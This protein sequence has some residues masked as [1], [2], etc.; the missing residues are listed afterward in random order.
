MLSRNSFVTWKFLCWYILYFD[1]S[2]VK[3]YINT[4]TELTFF[5]SP[6]IIVKSPYIYSPPPTLPSLWVAGRGFQ[7]TYIREQRGGFEQLQTTAKQGGPILFIPLYD[8]N[9]K[10]ILIS[11][12]TFRRHF[13]ASR[14][15]KKM[16]TPRS[17][18][19]NKCCQKT[20]W[21]RFFNRLQTHFE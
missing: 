19:L 13:M 12:L 20:R 6:Q 17:R 4:V 7:F 8:W 2:Y 18:K 16:E 10:G 1:N 14:S 15:L 9:S 5:H 21:D 3:K 11:C